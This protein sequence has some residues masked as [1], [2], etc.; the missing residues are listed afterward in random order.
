LNENLGGTIE[1]L[2]MEC[3][4]VVTR[5]GGMVDAVRDGETGVLVNPSDHEDLARG[6][7]EVLR[8]PGKGKALGRAG[9]KLMLSRFTLKHTTDALAKLYEK[10]IAADTGK[11][12]R[13]SVMLARIF[14]GLPLFLYLVFKIFIWKTPKAAGPFRAESKSQP[15]TPE[16]HESISN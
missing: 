6:I 3:P 8:D 1:A 2:L 4:T 13:V 10:M 14:A 7:L 15:F 12:Y 11:H 16:V 9:R 5:V